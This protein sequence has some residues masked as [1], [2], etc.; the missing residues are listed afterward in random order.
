MTGVLIRRGERHRDTGRRPCDD[1]GRDWRDASTSPGMPRMAGHH[2]KPGE[3]WNTFS[4][5]APRG[6]QSLQRLDFGLQSLQ[7]GEK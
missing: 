7:N 4:L 1:A 3:A 6:N 5:T 2:Q